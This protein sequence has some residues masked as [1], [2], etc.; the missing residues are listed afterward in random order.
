MSSNLVSGF[1]AT[2]IFPLD[3]EK[4]LRKLPGYRQNTDPGGSGTMAVLTESCYDLL[5]EHCKQ[6]VKIKRK[7][8]GKK[9]TSIPGKIIETESDI[10]WTCRHC[11]KKW[12][13]DDGS[14]WIICDICDA[15]YHLECSGVQYE[16]EEYDE[17]DIEAITF[18]CDLCQK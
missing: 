1:A 10:T 11:N 7:P 2:G 5:R 14:R 17:F 16:T 18:S 6:P 15:A 4:V 13:E 12:K 9:V 3:A 8:R